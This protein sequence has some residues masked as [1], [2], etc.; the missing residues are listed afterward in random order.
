MRSGDLARA[1]ELRCEHLANPLG[2]DE[3]FPRL[4][5]K[6]ESTQR[7]ERQTA[8]RVLVASSAE[9]LARNVGDLWDSGK[10]ASDQSTLVA[11]AGR[12]LG[13]R[14]SCVWKVRVWDKDGNGSNWSEAASWTM[15]LL[16][17]SDW[18]AKWIGLDGTTEL[19]N[20]DRRLPAR[21]LR[22]EFSVEKP[23]K[24]AVVSVCGLGLF[25]LQVNGRK[26]GDHVLEPACSEYDKRA[27]YETFDV[28]AQL[29]AGSNAVGVILGN[30]R[31]FGPR[32]P[33]G[34]TS[35]GYP[36]LLLQLDLEYADG[37]TGQVVTDESWKLT[38]NGPLGANN[39]Y[40]GEEYDATREMTGWSQA[41]FDEG[42]WRPAALVAAGARFSRRRWTSRCG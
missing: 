19:T 8:Y 24:H 27:F 3:V 25:E 2:I 26:A 28:A 39:E 14:E 41:G 6:L 10:V 22:K 20:A 37:S 40:D 15:G 7:G 5:W 34:T 29:A 18:Q 16:H 1:G 33:G 31:F 32:A 35:F 36:K 17:I 12:P 23:V 21:Y 11:Y 9:T 42:A 13:S 38:T 30:G 4:S